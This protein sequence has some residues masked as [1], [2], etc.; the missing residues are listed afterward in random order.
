MKMCLLKPTAVISLHLNYNDQKGSTVLY[1]MVFNRGIQ[2]LQDLSMESDLSV[3]HQTASL[4]VSKTM[5]NL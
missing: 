3:M 5:E 4:L 1:T 2:T